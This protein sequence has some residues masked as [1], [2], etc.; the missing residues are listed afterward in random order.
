MFRFAITAFALLTLNFCSMAQSKSG[1]ELIESDNKQEVIYK[2]P[3]TFEDI[4]NVAAFKLQ[5]QAET[6][7]PGEAQIQALSEVLPEFDMI[8]FLGTWCE[9]SHNLVPKLYRV[10]QETGYP[11]DKPDIQAL[12]RDKKGLHNIEDQFKITNVPTII[13][14]KNGEETGRITETVKKSIEQ[15]L[16]DIAVPQ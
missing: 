6:Y 11:L 14:L 13:L 8:I 16:L 5:E 7:Q 12:D 9:D 3:C 15:D 4:A 1:Y 2:G 10:L